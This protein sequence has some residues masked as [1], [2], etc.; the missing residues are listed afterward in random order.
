[1]K[2]N[3]FVMAALALLATACT[4][5][6]QPADQTPA[7]V[8]K[9]VLAITVDPTKAAVDETDGAVNFQTGDELAV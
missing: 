3:L 5:E 6:Q 2:K 9:T 7:D 1:M 8:E 4:K